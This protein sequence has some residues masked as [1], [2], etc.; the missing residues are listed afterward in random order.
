[1]QEDIINSARR[2]LPRWRP[3]ARTPVAE[4]IPAR[5][6]PPDSPHNKHKPTLEN[7]LKRWRRT[8][9]LT[10]A[11]DLLDAALVS[12]NYMVAVPAAME[13]SA[14]KNAVE[15]L[16][17]AA[18]QILGLTPDRP[19]SLLSAEDEWDSGKISRCYRFIEGAI[20][21]CSARCAFRIGSR[22]P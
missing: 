13:V 9:A 5:N 12:G 4:L 15:G 14:N 1:M 19:T 16:H 18:Q 8:K 2:I 3:V 17:A 11:A 7:M 22:P 10:D 21:N 6:T 20:E